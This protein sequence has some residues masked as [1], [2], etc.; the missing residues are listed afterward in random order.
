MVILS[1]LHK[2]AWLNEYKCF[3][4][5]SQAC[6]A[7]LLQ[8]KL[9]GTKFTYK[10]SC[11]TIYHVAYF[12][13]KCAAPRLRTLKL[14]NNEKARGA[15]GVFVDGILMQFAAGRSPL[16]RVLH[17]HGVSIGEQGVVAFANAVAAG[18]FLRLQSL[19]FVNV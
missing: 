15:H 16:L 7:T 4:Q 17:L 1:F 2:K 9:M 12:L 19:V 13:K 18:H 5:V 3:Y 11:R 6:R 8:T 14:T 10:A